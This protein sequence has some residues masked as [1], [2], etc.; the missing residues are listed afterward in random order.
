MVTVGS[1]VIASKVLA[2]TLPPFTA[3]ALR[4]AIAIIP[5]LVLV[6]FTR[7]PLPAMPAA[8]WRLLGL[9][10]LAGSIGYTALLMAGLRFTAATDAAIILGLLP[11][12]AALFAV[13]FLGERPGKAL[14][15]ALAVAVAGVLLATGTTAHHAGSWLGRL[16]ILGA[17]ACEALFALLNRKMTI[18]V[19]PL[20]LS[21]LTCVL[22]FLLTAVGAL[23]EHPWSLHYPPQALAAVLYY[24]LI[25]TVAGFLLWYACL[26]RVRAVEASLLTAV[27]PIAAIVLAATVLGEPVTRNAVAGIL[28]VLGAVSCYGLHAR[29]ETPAPASPPATPPEFSVRSDI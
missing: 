21:T 27:A 20:M 24:A 3:T 16:L 25:P 10:A 17:V 29:R 19:P 14:W 7:T 9:Q 12:V 8:D 5:F 26:E 11:L 23:F 15:A 4:F 22:G 13:G 2:A 28:I 6:R 1:A 18:K